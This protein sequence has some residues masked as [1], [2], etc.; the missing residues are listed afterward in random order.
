MNVKNIIGHLFVD[1]TVILEIGVEEN[2]TYYTKEVYHGSATNLPH[3]W[4]N[5]EIFLIVP[6]G[7]GVMKI[8]TR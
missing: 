8:I 6:Q 4:D 2:N 7:D 1:T 5:K 3:D